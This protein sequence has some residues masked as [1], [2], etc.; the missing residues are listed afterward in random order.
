MLANATTHPPR[1]ALVY[2][3]FL[4]DPKVKSALR[5]QKEGKYLV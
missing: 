4:A 2:V 5:I 3:P 1:A